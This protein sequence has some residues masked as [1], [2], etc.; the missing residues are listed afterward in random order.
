MS[1]IKKARWRVEKKRKQRVKIQALERQKFEPLTDGQYHC[2]CAERN[3]E[4]GEKRKRKEAERNKETII[5]SDL[6][7]LSPPPL[8][9]PLNP[10]FVSR[11]L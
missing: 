11:T 2:T 8:P 3:L 6:F 5:S 1:R 10:P 9:I 7:L 4:G